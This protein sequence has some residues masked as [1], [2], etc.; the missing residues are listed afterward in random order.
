MS[1]EPTAKEADFF[2]SISLPG[3]EPPGDRVGAGY[4]KALVF[5]SRVAKISPSTEGN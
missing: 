1:H 5:I 3:P 4:K 2:I